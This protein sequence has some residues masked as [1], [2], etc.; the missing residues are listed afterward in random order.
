MLEPLLAVTSAP[1]ASAQRE[2]PTAER[3]FRDLLAP[4]KPTDDAPTT[5][6]LPAND[7]APQPPICSAPPASDDE[8][9]TDEPTEHAEEESPDATAMT[10]AIAVAPATPSAPPVPNVE[11]TEI[12]FAGE[13]IVEATV[14]A[15]KTEMPPAAV[16]LPGE[17]S[18]AGEA[19]SMSAAPIDVSNTVD[20][21]ATTPA[22]P[23]AV[24][25]MQTLAVASTQMEVAVADDVAVEEP[26]SATTNTDVTALRTPSANDAAATPRDSQPPA[27]APQNGRQATSPSDHAVTNVPLATAQVAEPTS[28]AKRTTGKTRETEKRETKGVGDVGAKETADA[29]QD[30]AA[31]GVVEKLAPTSLASPAATE[32]ALEAKANAAVEAPPTRTETTATHSSPP[33]TAERLGTMLAQR[34]VKM[35]AGGH[36]PALTESQQARLVQRVARAFDTARM[37]GDAEMRLRLSPPELGALKLEV[38]MENGVMTARLEVE[39]VAAQQALSDNLGTLRQRLAEQN[40]RVEQFDIDLMDRHNGNPSDSPTSQFNHDQRQAQRGAPRTLQAERTSQSVGSVAEPR[41]AAR[42]SGGLDVLI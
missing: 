32:A 22:E 36:G 7:G 28:S 10:A 14:L 17:E 3:A 31:V 25:Q 15:A 39:T 24:A 37:R 27:H 12:D 33:A 18:C 34:R 13:T 9:A 40:I 1:P 23:L 21:A 2:A 19:E 41:T 29:P 38:R 26:A 35:P 30:T 11:A 16:E 42:A 6:S 5:E 20:T 4:R 8:P